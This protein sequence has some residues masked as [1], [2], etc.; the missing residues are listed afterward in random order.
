MSQAPDATSSPVSACDE[1]S[2]LEEVIVG[3]IE[4]AVVPDEPDNMLQATVPT[5]HP[6]SFFRVMGEEF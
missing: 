4:G 5:T 2:L 1:W 3:R 6:Q